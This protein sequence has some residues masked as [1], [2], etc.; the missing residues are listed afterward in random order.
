MKAFCGLH[1]DS[2]YEDFSSFTNQRDR[3]KEMFD[4]ETEG[5]TTAMV[6]LVQPDER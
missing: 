1:L 6:Q 2:R 3:I 5:A 4:E